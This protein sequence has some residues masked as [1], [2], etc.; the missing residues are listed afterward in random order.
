MI[1][2]FFGLFVFVFLL[3]THSAYAGYIFGLDS[4]GFIAGYDLYTGEKIASYN[5]QGTYQ[6]AGIAFGVDGTLYARRADEL[7]TV[8]KFNAFSGDVIGEF[9]TGYNSESP[10]VV[11]DNGHLYGIRSSFTSSSF[12]EFDPLTGTI[13]DHHL[14]Y[15]NSYR[16]IVFG[17]DGFLYGYKT[18]IADYLSRHYVSTLK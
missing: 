10:M 4:N 17:G 1:D 9:A 7:G 12:V 13:V 14:G 5:P 15:L 16:D 6:G 3:S 18:G 8:V 11:D 2:A